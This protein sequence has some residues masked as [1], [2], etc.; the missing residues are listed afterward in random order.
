MQFDLYNYNK[1]QK[2][3]KWFIHTK[4]IFIKLQK[5]EQ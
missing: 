4:S 5:G 1:I 3:K 2:F